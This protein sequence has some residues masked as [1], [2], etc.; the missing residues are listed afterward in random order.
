M[1]PS[2][3]AWTLLVVTLLLGICIGVLGAG[4]LQERR[5]ARVNEDRKSVV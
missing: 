3:R 4:A 1:T 2:V 5:V